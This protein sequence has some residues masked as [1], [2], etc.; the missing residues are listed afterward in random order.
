MASKN[1]RPKRQRQTPET[2]QDS[3]SLQR[4]VGSFFSGLTGLLTAIAAFI[5]AIIAILTTTGIVGGNDHHT[6]AASAKTSQSTTTWAAKANAICARAND[7][8]Q[9]LPDANSLAHKDIPSYLKTAVVLEQRMLRQLNDLTPPP[10][11]AKQINSFLRIGASMSDATSELAN[12]VAL[13]N[14]IAAQQRANTLSRLNTQFNNAAVDLGARTC[15]EGSSL[16]D[17]FGG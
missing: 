10:E 11:K 12:D 2:Q 4:R 9:A 7:T 5:G 6:D 16:G 15:A 17:V 8:T 1:R 3:P 13:G 14:L